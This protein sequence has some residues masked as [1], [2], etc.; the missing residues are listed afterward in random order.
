VNKKLKAATIWTDTVHING[1]LERLNPWDNDHTPDELE[2]LHRECFDA[3]RDMQ[4]YILRD[5]ARAYRVDSP[6]ELLLLVA[7]ASQ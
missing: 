2:T 6:E 3:L 4:E 5:Q 7:E 1:L